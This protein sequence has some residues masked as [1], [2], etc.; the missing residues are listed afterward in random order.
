MKLLMISPNIGLPAN[1]G[2]RRRIYHLMSEL[3]KNNQICL[4]ALL[5]NRSEE[6]FM[7][8]IKDLCDQVET[9]FWD[10]NPKWRV[11]LQSLK[12]SSPYRYNRFRQQELIDAVGRLV[13]SH[14]FDA[15]FIH[16]LE[17]TAYL[18]NRILSRGEPL[19]VVDYHNDDLAFWQRI[20]DNSD[21]I[22]Q[23]LFARLNVRYLRKFLEDYQGFIDVGLAVSKDDLKSLQN[24]IGDRSELW[25][26]P[27]GVDLDYFSG[28]RDL[29]DHP[30]ILFCGAL[31]MEMNIS[32]LRFFVQEIFPLVKKANP[33]CEF[34]IVG[35]NPDHRV[36]KYEQIPGINMFA[37]V[38]D[39]RPFYRK[40]WAA[41][42]PYYLGGGSKL[43]VLEAMAMRVPVVSTTIG[44][45]GVDV[46]DGKNILISDRPEPFAQLLNE[47]LHDEERRKMLTNQGRKLVEENYGWE[48]ISD[49]L[50]HKLKEKVSQALQSGH[51]GKHVT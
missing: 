51:T 43:K 38:P 47:L 26:V 16:F 9:Y 11:A 13:K 35:R 3:S 2:A 22:F 21:Y 14:D 39:V 17:F 34:W 44:A 19:I 10:K 33:E 28:E 12:N 23:R 46:E 50:D 24:K 4:V 41:V 49:N 30:V 31:D 45:Q 37:S 48:S 5:Q 6:K 15:I 8:E 20:A 36:Q 29:T 40:A 27:N 32:A 25:L 18:P 42:S 7:S 1:N